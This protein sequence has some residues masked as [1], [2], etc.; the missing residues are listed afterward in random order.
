MD[1]FIK[2]LQQLLEKKDI[3]QRE[4]A[5]RVGVSEVT[6]SRYMSGERNPRIEIVRKMADVLSVTTDY[7]LGNSNETQTKESAETAREKK[8]KEFLEMMVVALREKGVVGDDEELTKEAMELL[9]KYGLDAGA[10]IIAARKKKQ[11]D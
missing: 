5:K 8:M 10:E 9:L 6:I 1:D 4:L 7:L 2:R 3:S 11:V